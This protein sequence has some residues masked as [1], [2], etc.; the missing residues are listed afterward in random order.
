ME[1]G[2]QVSFTYEQD[3]SLGYVIVDEVDFSEPYVVRVSA[4]DTFESLGAG[5]SSTIYRDGL[6]AS[7]SDIALYDVCYYQS[8]TD[9]VYVYSDKISGV[10]EEAY[11]SK[12]NVSSVLIS[13]VTLSIETQTAA[14]KLGEKSGSYAYNSRV[15]VLLGKDGGIVDIVDL[16]SSS[17]SLYG[18]L[19]SVESKM[20]DNSQ[21]TY[22]N[23][24][25]GG[26][27]EASFKTQSNYSSKIGY[28]GKISFDDDGYAKFAVVTDNVIYGEVDS[29][30][31]KI[32]SKWLSEDCKIIELLYV[33][34]SH[35][36]TAKAQ[37]IELSELGTTLTKSQCVY[38]ATGGS[39]GDIIAMFVTDVTGECYE[40]GVVKS[41]KLTES[42]SDLSGSYEIFTESGSVE[43]LSM[44]S[45]LNVSSG[46]GVKMI[47]SGNKIVSLKALSSLKTGAKCTAFDYS[48]I[49]I[50]D[51]IYAVSSNALV[52]VQTSSGYKKV[53]VEDAQD[54]IGK[55]VRVYT[56][57]SS[58][59]DAEAKV[60]IFENK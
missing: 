21:V 27:T 60:I 45:Y 19:L 43:S 15:T 25:T 56:D 1:E 40:Y 13:G 48:R 8:G 54:Y 16:S 49:R 41:A 20:V 47:R 29:K 4:A 37:V 51:S 55:T 33:P 28:V 58:S 18:V 3:G 23:V 38:A 2:A 36:G 6:A 11:P 42:A 17:A 7:M 31:G 35:T 52:V 59:K 14:Y 53:S 12:A 34:D 39:F 10:Y 57:S 30:N 44:D 9:T 32:G 24:L 5:S 50:G 22:I 46:L 26:G